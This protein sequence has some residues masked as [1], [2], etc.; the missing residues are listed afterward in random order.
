MLKRLTVHVANGKSKKEE[1]K[2]KAGEKVKVPVI[3]NT[4]SYRNIRSMDTV[5]MIMEELKHQ[6][7]EV[8]K[9]YLSNEK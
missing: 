1:R 4:L 6:K 8:K 5:D 2:N 9:Y 7:V 3:Y